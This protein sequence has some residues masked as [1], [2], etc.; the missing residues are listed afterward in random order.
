MNTENKRINYLINIVLLV[1]SL[2]NSPAHAQEVDIAIEIP[3]AIFVLPRFTGP[4]SEREASIAPE[5]YELADKFQ[6]LLEQEDKGQVLTQL[7]EYYDIEL[8]PAM[9]TLKAQIYF[10]LKQY[11]KAEET[12]LAV[13][14]RKP[15]LMRVHADMGQLY[16]VL[17]QPLKAREHFAKA[18]N[19]G[20]NDASIH[21]QLAYLNLTYFGPF[22]AI[23]EYQQAM[24]LEPDNQQWYR[25]LLAALLQAKMFDS[26]QALLDE[27]LKRKSDDS[28]LWLMN[29]TLALKMGDK[30][31]ALSGLEMA[32]LL[33][34]RSTNNLKTAAQLHLQ[35]KSYDRAVVLLNEILGSQELSMQVVDEYLR[36]MQQTNLWDEASRM[37]T[38]LEK[39]LEK[40]DQ[41]DK[42]L[43]YMHRANIEVHR[44]NYTSAE[45]LFSRAIE[46]NPANGYALLDYAN[47]S[48]KQRNSVRAEMLYSR[49]EAIPRVEKQAL[50]DR[51]Q[52]YLNSK[53]YEKALVLM[54]QVET[55]FPELHSI[56]E[57]IKVVE[58]ILRANQS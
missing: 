46:L 31:K 5:E 20:L 33:G 10:S 44:K 19:Y 53:N 22:S 4:Y 50:L 28:D 39:R 51:I 47:F 49:A 18:V 32:I 37:L 9:L 25:G 30:Q 7:E 21:G 36:W 16:L 12:Y 23:S 40:L 34:D 56:S 52:F 54:R 41:M 38:S 15:Q 17:E 58:N 43:F 27:L 11:K 13:L 45:N 14:S 48:V 3:K 26:A 1:L 24:S 8:S 6:A 2:G 42:S 35:L 57:N 55:K 29:A